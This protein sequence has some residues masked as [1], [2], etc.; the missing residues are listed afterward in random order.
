MALDSV[1]F[2]AASVVKY[3]LKGKKTLNSLIQ[4]DGLRYGN[5]FDAKIMFPLKIEQLYYF[6]WMFS[7]MDIFFQL[8][9][10]LMIISATF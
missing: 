7:V 8:V 5:Y 6:Y 3:N 1:K 10:C 9:V 4:I 2:G